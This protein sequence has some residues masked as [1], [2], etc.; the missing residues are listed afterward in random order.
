MV[1]VDN[2]A[3][4]YGLRHYQILDPSQ[5]TPK[6]E[7]L[8]TKTRKRVLERIAEGKKPRDEGLGLSTSVMAILESGNLSEEFTSSEVWSQLQER[9]RS[10]IKSVRITDLFNKGEL[11]NKV[12]DTGKKRGREKV[13]RSR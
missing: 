3:K 5:K 9:T 11:K 4:I 12:I 2:I 7:D 1:K 8:P 13:Y 10:K 6:V